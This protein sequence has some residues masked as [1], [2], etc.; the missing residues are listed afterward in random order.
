M[1]RGCSHC[2]APLTIPV[3]S[4]V[5][6]AADD[7]AA[8]TLAKKL[9]ND[10]KRLGARSFCNKISVLAVTDDDL[11]NRKTAGLVDTPK[12]TKNCIE[13]L[14][15]SDSDDSDSADGDY[16]ED[17]P[18]E[19]VG[20]REEGK[21]TTPEGAPR[22]AARSRT[23]FSRAAS[24]S[25]SR[26][27]ACSHSRLTLEGEM[28]AARE[29][30][31]RD[32]AAARGAPSGVVNF[33]VGP[34]S[35]NEDDAGHRNSSDNTRSTPRPTALRHGDLG[36]AEADTSAASANLPV[37]YCPACIEP[38][39]NMSGNMSMVS[40]NI[41]NGNIHRFCGV[42]GGTRNDDGETNDFEGTRCSPC[43]AANK[44]KKRALPMPY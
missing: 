21:L 38:E 29:K 12:Q 40:C 17:E 13:V 9:R 11:N 31:V 3:K 22:A 20:D 33:P 37:I 14:S 42:L 27:K 44:G 36:R 28:D 41:C 39:C 10:V 26:A 1:K 43:A 34:D 8:R 2:C 23:I 25:P 5:G 35:D 24:I 16:D 19:Y 30:I 32:L 6:V 4:W 7:D 18:I 15:D